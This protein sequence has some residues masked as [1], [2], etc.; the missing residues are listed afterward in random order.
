MD[1]KTSKR[2]ESNKGR[3][4]RR[5]KEHQANHGRGRGRVESRRKGAVERQKE[6]NRHP[7]LL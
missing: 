2:R 7:Y 6:G 3:R 4:E 5:R 1:K